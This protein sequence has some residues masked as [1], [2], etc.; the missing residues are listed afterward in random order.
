MP[1]RTDPEFPPL[2][3]LPRGMRDLD[4]AAMAHR[5]SLVEAVGRVYQLHG[6]TP[7]ETP[8][9]E[10]AEAL[11][12]HLPD[13]DRETGGVFTFT[14]GDG[15]AL[16]L[17]YDM[18][19][20][21]ARYAAERR[22][23]LVLPLRRY[24]AGPVWRDEKAGP[25][26]FREFWQC[27]ADTLGAPA[28][29]AD[30]EMCATL[31]A[32]LE[33]LNL[34]RD[35][36][37][38]RLS[39]RCL[40]DGVLEATGLGGPE[41]ADQRLAVF[42][43]VDKLERLGTDGVRDLLQEGRRDPSGDFTPGAGLSE[44]QAAR[45]LAFVGAG[46]ADS[47][48]TLRT[49]RDIVGDTQTGQ[50]GI[51]TL[52]TILALLDGFPCGAAA[53]R[54]DPSVVRGLAY[55]TGPV[56]EA[57]LTFTVP[58]PDGKPRQ[59]G[60]VAGGG[61]YDDLV[62][63]FGGETLPATGVSL[64]VDRLAAALEAA[65]ISSSAEAHGPVL[66]LAMG[67]MAAHQRAA[68]ELRSAGIAAEAFVGTGGMRR[69]MRYADRRTCPVVVIEGENE[70]AEGTVVIKNLRL[71]SRIARQTATHEE[72]KEHRAQLEVPRAAMTATVQRILAEESDGD[73][74]Q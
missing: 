33:A 44:P 69:Q 1:S 68:A 9:I 14:D 16:A 11:G 42:R 60:S 59:F 47:A 19:A 51:E 13:D 2:A 34:S 36:F 71:G 57:V 63:R 28:G 26:R 55:Y 15:D 58:G 56:F 6:F 66:V 20:P 5:Q 3:S 21:L 12:A 29:A 72:W 53:A 70:R 43:A 4:G 17:R 54:L 52:E 64:G 35:Q 27:D 50:R 48:T 65:G 25:G 67:D 24:T 32:V 23:T 8:A 30:A 45:I 22:N 18:T 61:R 10:R 37:E 39:D 46:G 7:L 40:L 41:R 62:R 31:A 73:S 74:A 38:I 49:L